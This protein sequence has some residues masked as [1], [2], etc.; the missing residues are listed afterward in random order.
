MDDTP[1]DDSF[2]DFIDKV[3]QPSGESEPENIISE[4]E[5]LTSAAVEELEPHCKICGWKPR[6]HCKNKHKALLRHVRDKHPERVEEFLGGGAHP[7]GT[8][9]VPVMQVV[10]DI[11]DINF[12][13]MDEDAQKCKL[14]EDLDILKVKFP[15]LYNVPPYSY[16]ETPLHTLQRYKNTYQ[17]L[18]SDRISSNVAFNCLVMMGKGCERGTAMMGVCDIEGYASDLIEK[19]AEI[20]EVLQECID[21]NVI[22]VNDIDPTIKLGLLLFNIGV[23]RAHTNKKNPAHIT[24]GGTEEGQ[25]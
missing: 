2:S 24:T 17:R 20:M 7:V 10:H 16:P 8:K 13:A 25:V 22:C 3:K 9:Q 6:A 14:L 19:Q 15:G 23:H 12:N 11:E 21:M 1:N 18:V 4:G 5:P